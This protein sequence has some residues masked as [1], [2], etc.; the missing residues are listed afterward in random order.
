V[1][2]GTIM[3]T[4]VAPVHVAPAHVCN[5]WRFRAGYIRLLDTAIGVET[6]E[7]LFTPDSPHIQLSLNGVEII[8][9][10]S[11]SHHELRKLNTRLDLIRSATKRSGGVYLYVVH[12]MPLLAGYHRKRRRRHHHHHHHLPIIT[13]SICMRCHPPM[14]PPNQVCEP[15]GM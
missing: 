3:A 5:W 12:V 14:H 11:G 2:L 6:C 13:H 15:A 8:G 4:A 9:N 10:G 7:E 1:N